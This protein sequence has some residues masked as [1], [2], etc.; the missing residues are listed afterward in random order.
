M[1]GSLQR[2]NNVRQQ[3][4]T[5]TGPVL[6]FIRRAE[7]IRRTGIS[8]SERQILARRGE[9]PRQV[10]ISPRCV[11]WV[12]DEIDAWCRDRIAARDA[13]PVVVGSPVRRLHPTQA[14]AEAA[15]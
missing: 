11:A 9:F 15:A 10:Q 4:P 6:R 8:D 12:E 2:S 13:T 7:V 14:A 1:H 3:L 5:P